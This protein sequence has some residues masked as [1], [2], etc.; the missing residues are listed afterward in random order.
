MK[1]R[2]YSGTGYDPDRIVIATSLPLPVHHRP[3]RPRYDPDCRGQN[4]CCYPPE[5]LAKTCATKEGCKINTLLPISCK[6]RGLCGSYDQKPW[7]FA[8]SEEKGNPQACSLPPLQDRQLTSTCKTC[9]TSSADPYDKFT[10]LEC[11]MQEVPR[12]KVSE[13]KII[14]QQPPIEDPAILDRRRYHVPP[15]KLFKPP[16]ACCKFTPC[17]PAHLEPGFHSR[18]WPVP[19]T[20]DAYLPGDTE[21]G[22]VPSH[23]LLWPTTMAGMFCCV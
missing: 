8:A 12:P 1:A 23:A 3:P 10:P 21:L 7:P 5:L 2:V 18:S 4:D 11:C 22:K 19:D 20:V 9:L 13:I 16:I 14:P 15:P 17:K 6:E